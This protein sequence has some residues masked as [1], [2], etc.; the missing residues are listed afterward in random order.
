MTI[1]VQKLLTNIFGCVKIIAYKGFDEK[2]VNDIH[3]E[4]WRLVRATMH[5]FAFVV[6]EP[7]GRKPKG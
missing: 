1:F 5:V 2:C 7:R 4:K 3:T 6:S